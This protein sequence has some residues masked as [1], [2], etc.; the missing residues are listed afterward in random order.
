LHE[1]ELNDTV[2]LYFLAES[3]CLPMTQAECLCHNDMKNL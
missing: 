3:P 2:A 1:W